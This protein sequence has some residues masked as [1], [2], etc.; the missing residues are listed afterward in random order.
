MIE[1]I[2]NWHPIFVHFTV[3]LLSLAVVFHFIYPFFSNGKIKQHFNIL[4]RWNLWL[5]TG[6]GIITAI[7]G[8]FAYNSVIHDTPSHAVMTEH[9]NW[10][11]LT[12]TLFIFLTA[13]SLLT[14]IKK[15]QLGRNFLIGL[16][17]AGILL[18]CTAWHGAESVYRYGIG[19]M[20]LPQPEGDD[21][22]HEHGKATKGTQS[23]VLEPMGN[24]VDSNTDVLSGHQHSRDQSAIEI[25][26]ETEGKI[27][28][29]VIQNTD[30][31]SGHQ[32]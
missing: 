22:S 4:A 13:W 5:G 16:L 8:W 9:R 14:E 6:F 2:P 20:S 31:H 12:I 25:E 18:F 19:V 11:L 10:A 1:I 21:H 24:H 32:H 15:R 27:Q 3:A 30:D 28:E 29:P 23:D 26:S 7:A 17:I